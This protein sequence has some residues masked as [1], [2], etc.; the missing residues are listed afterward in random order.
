MGLG[1][2]RDTGESGT[3]V[4]RL[5]IGGLTTGSGDDE[6]GFGVETRRSFES[7]SMA[8]RVAYMDS[9]GRAPEAGGRR[10]Q[11]L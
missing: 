10:D 9:I 8:R 7:T 3:Q 1:V 6:L 11:N 2:T 5:F 4:T